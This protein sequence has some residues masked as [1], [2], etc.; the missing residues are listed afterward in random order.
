M[1]SRAPL[2]D[3]LNQLLGLRRWLRLPALQGMDEAGAHRHRAVLAR[4]PVLYF[5]HVEP[6][7]EQRQEQA[8][9]EHGVASFWPFEKATA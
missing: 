7:E 8:K 5:A 3:R 9:C 4:R 2:T 1:G 6:R